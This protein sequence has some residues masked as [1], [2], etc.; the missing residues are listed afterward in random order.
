MLAQV[1]VVAD[2]GFL[3]VLS[4]RLQ[5]VYIDGDVEGESGCHSA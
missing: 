1:R 2:V 4:R 3:C 5:Q